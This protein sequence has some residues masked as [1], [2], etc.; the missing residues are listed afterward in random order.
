M[1]NNVSFEQ[2]SMSFPVWYVSYISIMF[3]KCVI[4]FVILGFFDMYV[5]LIFFYAMRLGSKYITV[6]LPKVLFSI[7]LVILVNYFLFI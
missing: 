2:E 6:L 5:T 4:R 7:P 1:R 3:S